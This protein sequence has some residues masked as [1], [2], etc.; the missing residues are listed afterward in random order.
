MGIDNQKIL[1]ATVTVT[2]LLF[3]L[4]KFDAGILSITLGVLLVLFTLGYNLVSALFNRQGDL[5]RI[6]RVTLSFR[7]GI[8]IVLLVGWYSKP[9]NWGI[10]LYPIL[11]YIT[12]Y[13]I[14]A[15][16][17]NRDGQQKLVKASRLENA[18]I[19]SFSQ[20]Y[21]MSWSDI[22]LSISPVAVK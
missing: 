13:F 11:L 9:I 12:I 5:S 16:A 15:S 10:S 1:A 14:D 18:S 6:E 17:I 3:L 8:T 2:L 22:L 7:L 21:V 20:S 19:M 4:V